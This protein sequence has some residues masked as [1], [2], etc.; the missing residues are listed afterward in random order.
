[1]TEAYKE[2]FES[3]TKNNGEYINPY[4]A[5]DESYNE[6]ERGWS[7]AL[8]KQPLSN[9]INGRYAPNGIIQETRAELEV[10][11][12]EEEKQRN[13]SEYIKAKGK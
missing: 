10:K 2:G 13:M 4:K 6:F 1:M 9:F 12:T 11:L 3:F 7:Q 8:K 5:S